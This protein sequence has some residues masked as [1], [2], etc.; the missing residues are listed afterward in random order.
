MNRILINATHQEEL[1]V[2]LVDGQT[3]YDLDIDRSVRAQTKSNIY[4]GVI[5]HVA[6]ALEAVFVNYGAER[7]GFL[8]LKEISPEYFAVSATDPNERH[9]IKDLVHEGQEIMVQIE[10][11]ERGNK[12]AALTTFISLAGSYLVAMPNNPSAGGI[13]RRIE[14]EDRSSMRETINALQLPEGMGVIVRTAGVGRTVEELQSDLNVLITL[15]E[16]IKTASSGRAAPFLI[17]QEGDVV[18][19]TIRDYLRQEVGEILIDSEEVYQK[20]KSYIQR[21]KPDMLDRVKLY[22]D[23]VPLFNRFQIENQ[24]ET[25]HERLIRLPSGGSIVVDHTEALVSI[26]I[27]SAKATKGSDIEETALNTNLEAAAEIG[28]QL[29]LRDLSGLIVIDFIDMESM[30]NKRAI[31]NKLREELQMDRARV[32]VGRIS[33]FGLLEMSRQRLRSSLEESTHARCPRCSGH[34]TVRSIESLALSVIRLIEE[35][36]IKPKTVQIQ[37]QLPIEVATY[38]LNE[39]RQAI[40]QIEQQH[41]VS[42]L[43]IPNQYLQTPQYKVERIKSDETNPLASNASYDLTFKP[44]LAIPTQTPAILEGSQPAVKELDLQMASKPTQK[45]DLLSQLIAW[46]TKKFKKTKKVQPPA[47]FHRHRHPHHHHRQRNHYQPRPQRQPVAAVSNKAVETEN[48]QVVQATTDETQTKPPYRRHY[49]NKRRR[50][51]KP[52]PPGSPSSTPTTGAPKTS[53]DSSPGNTE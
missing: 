23:K 9:N 14:G 31:E 10:K 15:W 11:E 30:R 22:Q 25:A 2:A 6:P 35:D 49:R 38:L 28:R 53:S 41:K 5:T 1:R 37:A 34:G 24:I 8:P 26:D 32:Q 52:R 36:A 12:G 48:V 21:V 16:A 13:S 39:K 40:A 4:W 19:R 42:I 20:A 7:H 45:V 18:I 43:V 33:R 47:K 46:I 17:H 51:T 3:L 44:E 27:N 50:Y 29:R